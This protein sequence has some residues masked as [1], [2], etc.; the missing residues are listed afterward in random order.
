[1]SHAA[2]GNMQPSIEFNL[3]SPE[4]IRFVNDGP[5]NMKGISQTLLNV[6]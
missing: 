3:V 6:V 5:R 1:M 2:S 4:L